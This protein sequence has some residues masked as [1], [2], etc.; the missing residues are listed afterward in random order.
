MIAAKDIKQL[1]DTKWKK[2]TVAL[3]CFVLAYIVGSRAVDTGSWWEYFATMGL[4]L[5]SAKLIVRT[6]RPQNNKQ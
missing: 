5:I 2:V 3:V 1:L 6:I 4:L